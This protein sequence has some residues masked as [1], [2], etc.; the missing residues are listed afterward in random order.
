MTSR[1]LKTAA[2]ASLAIA[3]LAC[4]GDDGPTPTATTIERTPTPSPSDETPT[5][6]LTPAPAPKGWRTLASMPTPRSEVAVAA[7]AGQVY[8]VG[9]FEGDGSPS[10]AVEVYD[11]ATDTWTQAPPL[12]E[13]RHHTAATAVAD[14]FLYVI[15]GFGTTFSDPQSTVYRYD[16]TRQTWEERA[17]MP[18]ARGGHAVTADA[19]PGLTSACLYAIGGSD[20]G[21]ENVAEVEAYDDASNSWTAA[22]DLPTPRDHLVAQH[23]GAVGY[24]Y[25]I[26]GRRN[27]DFGENL[28]ANEEYDVDTDTWAAR[29][30]LP[31]ARS[32]IAAAFL[33][34][35]IYVFGGEGSQ[36]TFDENEAYDPQTDTWDTL[37]PMP[38][39]RHGLGAAVVG[40]TIYVIGGGE[41]PGL[42]VSG[43]NEAFTP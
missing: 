24:L 4:N 18:T 5:P 41:T 29:A 33:D 27:V 19:C 12:P 31:T 20:Q 15:G 17:P 26:G 35:R 22:A 38:T 3:A 8:V 2:L 9:G 23:S 10:D 42:S 25:A 1:I 36:G 28:D 21:Q 13:P 6:R 16:T 40:D 34:G 30:P 7:V 43:A 39:A 11:P 14:I 32:G 37:E